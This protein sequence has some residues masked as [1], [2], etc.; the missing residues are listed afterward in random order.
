MEAFALSPV[1][2]FHAGNFSMKF[3]API[4]LRA[5]RGQAVCSISRGHGSSDD[6]EHSTSAH[7]NEVVSESGIRQLVTW[8][9]AVRLNR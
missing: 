1:E 9:S 7:Y 5:S 8:S 2:F 4:L 6:D 3:A